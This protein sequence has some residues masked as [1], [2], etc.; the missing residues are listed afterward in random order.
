MRTI[1]GPARNGTLLARRNLEAFD[2]QI[3]P[4]SSAEAKLPSMDGDRHRRLDVFQRLEGRNFYYS[5][6]SGTSEVSTG[7][8]TRR[9][10]LCDD[11]HIR[12]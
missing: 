4:L 11:D 12:L 6:L 1:P 2:A 10:T 8:D 3:R 7:R 5:P 9:C